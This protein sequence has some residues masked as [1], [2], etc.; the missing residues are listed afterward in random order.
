MAALQVAKPG[1]SAGRAFVSEVSADR[2]MAI[3]ASRIA[4]APLRPFARSALNLGLARVGDRQAAPLLPASWDRPRPAA[5]RPSGC[6]PRPARAPVGE[7]TGTPRSGPAFRRRHRQERCAGPWRGKAPAIATR[8][9]CA[10]MNACTQQVWLVEF[11]AFRKM[12]SRPAGKRRS[13]RPLQSWIRMSPSTR[14][15]RPWMSSAI[16]LR[17]CTLR[18]SM[19]KKNASVPAGA[20]WP[21]LERGSRKAKQSFKRSLQPMA[22]TAAVRL[23]WKRD[24]SPRLSGVEG[25]IDAGRAD[26]AG[27]RRVQDAGIVVEGDPRQ[28]RATLPHGQARG[29]LVRD[30]ARATAQGRSAPEKG[31]VS[32]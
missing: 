20:R 3:F 2:A 30:A 1:S 32:R 22:P 15:S 5:R 25:R 9:T 14:P 21:S 10:T 29:R 7:A 31:G 11:P 8:R 26:A 18:Q 28:A 19:W 13:G 27:I 12:E 16:A 6:R 24:A 23:R 4:A 17:Q